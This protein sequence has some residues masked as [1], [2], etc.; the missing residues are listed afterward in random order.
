MTPITLLIAILVFTL[1]GC[2]FGIFTGLIPGIH[3]NNVAHMVLVSQTLI[4]SLATM[5]FGWADPETKDILIII[6]SL[7]IGTV[8]THTFL[9]FIPSVFLGAPDG[10]TA[11]SVLPGHRM[12]MEGRGFEAVKCS[13]TGSFGAM[14]FA[15]ILLI[16]LRLF[17]GEPV[18]AYTAM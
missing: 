5:L 11:L 15:L 6:S 17:I 14:I 8:V 1:I 4:I 16:P 13:A 18:N 10:D 3:V 12:L 7:I 2:G 9:D